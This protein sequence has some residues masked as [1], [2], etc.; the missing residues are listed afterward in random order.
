MQTEKSKVSNSYPSALVKKLNF[1]DKKDEEFSDYLNSKNKIIKNPQYHINFTCIGNFISRDFKPFSVLSATKNSIN[2][3]SKT[4]VVVPVKIEV[5]DCTPYLSSLNLQK[6][7]VEFRQIAPETEKTFDCFIN[8]IE[9]GSSNEVLREKIRIET[10]RLV[11]G[12][13]KDW[14]FGDRLTAVPL[15][16]VYRDT[17]PQGQSAFKSVPLWH[18]DFTS[19]LNS[20]VKSFSDTWTP[21]FASYFDESSSD[22]KDTTGSKNKNIENINVEG[23]VNVWFPLNDHVKS[24]TLAVMDAKGNAESVAYTAVRRDGSF[25]HSQGVKNP[26]SNPKYLKPMYLSSLGKSWAIVFN[27]TRTPHSA[28]EFPGKIDESGRQSVEVRVALAKKIVR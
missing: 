26:V 8:A 28:I 11:Q 10:A 3:A 27:S 6:N 23:M 22:S 12:K 4:G 14:G 7:G 1:C 20:V 13:I 25:F 18:I 24:S 15:D 17:R 21:R 2:K 5:E 16:A 9:N 19:D